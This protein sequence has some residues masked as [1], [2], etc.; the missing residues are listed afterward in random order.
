MTIQKPI[1]RVS[2]YTLMVRMTAAFGRHFL[3]KWA[4][5]K[6]TFIVSGAPK[7]NKADFG[8]G[9]LA[10]L[11]PNFLIDGLELVPIRR[12]YKALRSRLAWGMHAK[13]G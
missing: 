12:K 4:A 2:E 5:Q 1:P 8:R 3:W 9:G 6:F 10:H 13:P 11:D 7:R